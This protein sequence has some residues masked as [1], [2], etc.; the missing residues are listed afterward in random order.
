M[1]ILLLFIAFLFIVAVIGLIA[2]IAMNSGIKTFDGE[3]AINKNN[4]L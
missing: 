4:K 1:K 2:L 3:N